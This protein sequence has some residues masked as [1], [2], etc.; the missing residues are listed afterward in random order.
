MDL[1]LIALGAIH[2]CALPTQ[3][4]SG[5]V[6]QRRAGGHPLAATISGVL[7]GARPVYALAMRVARSPRS[8]AQKSGELAG[9]ALGRSRSHF[10]RSPSRLSD[11][12]V[13]RWCSGGGKPAATPI[14]G[15]PRPS[16]PGQAIAQIV[17]P[18]WT[19]PPL[20]SIAAVTRWRTSSRNSFEGGGMTASG[21]GAASP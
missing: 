2:R 20:A 5:K 14:S 8:F 21:T 6:G 1:N 19:L 18:S 15:A 9:G 3:V 10:G 12:P 17:V 16:P 4:Q 13:Y 7:I 11:N